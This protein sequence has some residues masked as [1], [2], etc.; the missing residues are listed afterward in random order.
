METTSTKRVALYIRVST[1][2][3]ALEG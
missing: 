3:Q 2:E 1:Q